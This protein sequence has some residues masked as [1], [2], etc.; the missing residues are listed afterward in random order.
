MTKH[1]QLNEFL[2]KLKK[3]PSAPK[4][5][6]YADGVTIGMMSN[7]KELYLVFSDEAFCQKIKFFIDKMLKGQIKKDGKKA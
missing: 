7:S 6:M 5:Y 4:F 2:D 3:M 1:P